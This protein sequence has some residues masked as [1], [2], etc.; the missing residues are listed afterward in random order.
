MLTLLKTLDSSNGVLVGYILSVSLGG[1][2]IHFFLH[3][4][5]KVMNLNSYM[6]MI[7]LRFLKELLPDM[8]LRSSLD[9]SF[10]S[11][12]ICISDNLVYEEETTWKFTGYIV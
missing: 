5:R 3:N 12:F 8:G 2:S 10:V 6:V 9:Y 1:N 11:I 7:R 4:N